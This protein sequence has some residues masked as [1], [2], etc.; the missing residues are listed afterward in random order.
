M[1]SRLFVRVICDVRIT[2][3]CIVTWFVDVIALLWL[4]LESCG[5]TFQKHSGSRR[6]EVTS[7]FCK[8]FLQTMHKMM[9]GIP[10]VHLIT[11]SWRI[12]L[13]LCYGQHPDTSRR[14]HLPSCLVDDRGCLLG[15]KMAKA[16]IW[17]PFS[18]YHWSR[19]CV[20]T[21]WVFLSY[22]CAL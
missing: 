15:D 16:C 12:C 14:A 2:E 1:I 8:C 13:G 7:L 21:Y 9:I 19:E 20:K 17:P 5:N 4:V 11:M 22:D 10:S 3:V 18:S 6:C